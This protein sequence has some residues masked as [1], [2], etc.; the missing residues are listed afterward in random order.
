MIWG[1][2]LAEAF[3]YALVNPRKD[4]LSALFIDKEERSR[5]Y[6]LLYVIIIACSAP[7]GWLVGWL[8]SVN[9]MLPFALNILVFG[10]CILL[11]ICSKTLRSHDRGEL[12]LTV[13]QAE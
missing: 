12:E 3:A 9:R 1:Y 2:T 8:S 11:V 5:A 13:E 10:V 4:S 7:F 6:G